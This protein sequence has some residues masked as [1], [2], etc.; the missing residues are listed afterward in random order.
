MGRRVIISGG[1]KNIRNGF[2][3]TLSFRNKF[4]ASVLAFFYSRLD[5]LCRGSTLNL[6]YEGK[7]LEP[8]SFSGYGGEGMPCEVNKGVDLI[9]IPLSA[10]WYPVFFGVRL[11]WIRWT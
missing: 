8:I 6:T 10:F 11:T 9:V 7:I 4:L 1:G 2:S 5:F 3:G